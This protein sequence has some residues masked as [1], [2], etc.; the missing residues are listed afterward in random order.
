V[1]S[2]ELPF[3]RNLVN[4]QPASGLGGRVH[5]SGMAALGWSDGSSS[6][7]WAKSGG[8]LIC[9]QLQCYFFIEGCSRC[10]LSQEARKSSY[11]TYRVSDEGFLFPANY[12]VHIGLIAFSYQILGALVEVLAFPIAL[13]RGR[14]LR[15][16]RHVEER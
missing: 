2:Y 1:V 12:N 4:G 11:T 14:L 9:L 15:L 5:V 8:C 10:L 7:I 6:V 3:L 16:S 13:W